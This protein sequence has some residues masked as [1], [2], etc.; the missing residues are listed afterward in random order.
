[1]FTVGD[2]TFRIADFAMAAGVVSTAGFM[3]GGLSSL[4]L[5]ML[6]F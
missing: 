5:I 2:M 6:F 4:V 1:M 3:L